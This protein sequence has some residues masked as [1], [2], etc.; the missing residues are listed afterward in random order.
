MATTTI[1]VTASENPTMNYGLFAQTANSTTIT[2]TTDELTLIDGGVGS[3]IVPANGFEVGDSFRLEMG[4]II[5]A[6][7]NDTIRIRLKSGSVV[8]VE[9]ARWSAEG[10]GR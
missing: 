6:H 10:G 8:V 2:T 1:N 5:S 7:N 3:L 9:V 4:G